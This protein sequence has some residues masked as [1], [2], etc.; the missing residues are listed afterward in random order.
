TPDLPAA[1]L[2]VLEAGGA[3]LPLDP[4]YPRERLAFMLEDSGARVLLTRGSLAGVFPEG[5]GAAVLD[6][7]AG[8]A[9]DLAAP[10]AAGTGPDGLA[11][12]LYTSGSTGRPKGVQVSHGA[13]V[14]FLVSM[15]REPGLR[16]DD[17]LLAV[18]SLSFDIAALELYLPLLAGARIELASTAVAGDGLRLLALLRAAGATFLQATPA[19]WRMLL[20]AGWEEG[21][22]LRLA[23]C[24]GE[25]L[26]GELAAHLLRRCG[27]LWNVYGPTETTVW[28]TQLRVEAAGDAVVPLGRPLAN[29]RVH[30]L[31]ARGIPV[32]PG[33]PG[34][35]WI[36]G[37]GVARGYL[38]RPDLTALRFAPDPF[39]PEPGARLYRTG[40][41][42]RQRPD[43]VLEFLGRADHQVKVRGFRIETGEVEAALAAHPAV[44]ETVVVVRAEGGDARLVA[45]VAA[46]EAPPAAA[47]LRDHLRRSLPEPMVPSAFVFLDAL[48]LTPNRKVDRKALPAPEVETAAGFVA[49]RTP[50]QEIVAAVWSEV[51]GVPRIGLEDDFFALGG[52]SLLAARAT[53]RLRGAFGVELPLRTLFEAPTP[54]ALAERIE[55]ARAGGETAAAPPLCRVSREGELPLSFAQE[56]LWFLAQFDPESAAY[57]MPAALRLRGGLDARALTAALS[58]ILRRHEVLR[59]VFVAVQGRPVQAIRPPAPLPLP[60]VDLSALPEA[61]AGA[62][63]R[64]LAREEARRPFDLARG[65]LARATLLQLGEREHAVLWNAHHTVSDGWSVG[66]LVQE[67]A[68]LYESAVHGRPSPLPEPPI[69][70]ADWAAWQRAWL[71][72][73]A[74]AGQIGVWKRLLAGAPESL[75]LATDRPRPAVQTFRGGQRTL[76]LAPALVAGLETSARGAGSTLFMLLA[77]AFGTLL[78]RASGQGSVVLGA[79]V[80]NRDLPETEGLL[81]LFANTLALPVP[82]Q[83]DPDFRTLLGRVREVVL[84][85][86]SVQSVPFEKL[87]EELRPERSLG[88]SPLFQVLLV[89]QNAPASRLELS[90]LAIEPLEAERDAALFDLSLFAEPREEGLRLRLEHNRDLFDPATASRMLRHLAT[91]LQGAAGQP[92]LRLSELPLLTA[93]ES[94]QVVVAWNDTGSAGSASACVHAL[95][96]HQ[97]GRRPAAVALL[98]GGERLTYGE[99]DRRSDALARRLR[100][101]GAGPEVLVAFAAGRSPG[102]L[103]GALGILKAGAAYVPL[104]PA[105]PKERLALMLEDSGA[106]ILLT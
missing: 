80:A 17:V 6:L 4:A 103:I 65:P 99:L 22:R 21:D 51:L 104:D 50:V 29:T 83:G 49:P 10:P 92:E 61:G 94:H 64:R 82:L 28:S 90:G 23:L 31:D 102:L 8:L 12:V 55:R 3:Y 74:L 106:P 96:S 34:E 44:R 53:S 1:L 85:A 7:E 13:L 39:S 95:I 18:T 36:G 15:L 57:N 2:G 105:Y 100:A 98:S 32:P 42:V 91:L 48:P 47:E 9:A 89:L 79:P 62:E 20:E 54:G 72:G 40:D 87:V 77:A 37:R 19:T 11:Y 75:D 69:Q 14:N 101:L 76:E 59:T 68:T 88:H 58:E 67:L 84:T 86:F 56:R 26:Q 35:L 70:Y 46:T 30:A 52:H 33:A 63:A 27:E 24:G 71:Q 25:A 97:A 66:V 93:A 43:G 16:P 5:H 60:R 38:G 73:E 78:H 81:G 45:Y 41:L